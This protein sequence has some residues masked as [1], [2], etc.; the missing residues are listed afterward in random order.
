LPWQPSD[1]QAKTKKADTP[2]KQRTWAHV[3]N[4][5]L[6]RT[7]DEVLAIKAANSVVGRAG[8][9]KGKPRGEA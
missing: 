5:E 1:S 6:E 7:G 2:K 8:N 4:S 3:A 9:Y